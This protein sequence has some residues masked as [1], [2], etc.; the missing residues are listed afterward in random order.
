MHGLAMIERPLSRTACYCMSMSV[1]DR[2]VQ[3]LLDPEQY[4]QLEREAA[5]T[6]RSVAAVIREAIGA[7]LTRSGGT[8]AAAAQ[9]L[10]RVADADAAPAD[11][12]LEVKSALTAALDGKLA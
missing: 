10:L 12:W 1:L 5:R 4:E 8:R 7:R 6:G 9:R 2:R 3:L 11:E